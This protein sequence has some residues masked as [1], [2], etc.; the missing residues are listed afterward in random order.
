MSKLSLQALNRATLHRQW[1][2]ERHDATALEAIEHLVGLQAQSPQAP[3]AGLWTRLT[4]FDPADLV[5]LLE[6][7]QAVRG[8]MM[9]ATIRLMPSRDFLAFR[10]L[11]QPAWSARSTRTPPTTGTASRAST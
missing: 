3:Y 9:R 10:P 11:I 4:N 7:R 8:S 1:L 6:T 5:T 2:L